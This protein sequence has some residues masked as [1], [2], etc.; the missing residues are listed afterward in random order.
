M[1]APSSAHVTQLLLAWRNGEPAALDE[2]TPLVY[3][4]LHKIAAAYLR[5]ERQGHTLQTSGLVN[6]AFMRLVDQR[7]DWQNRAHFFGIA[8]QL[9]R[10]ILVDYARAR[11]TEKRGG[12]QVHFALDEALDEAESQNAD[13]VALDDA[14]QSLAKFDPRQSR[15]VELRYFGGLTIREVAEVMDLSDSTVEREWNTARLWLRREMT[16]S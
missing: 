6:E 16:K 1:S 10:R 3:N 2:L 4:E 12:D 13:L 9:M 8:A 14:L 5:R 15:I 11:Q 7:L